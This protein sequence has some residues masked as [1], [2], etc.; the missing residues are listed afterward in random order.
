[1]LNTAR[2]S[3]LGTASGLRIFGGTQANYNADVSDSLREKDCTILKAKRPVGAKRDLMI[4]EVPGRPSVLGSH[5][6]LI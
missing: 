3:M 2:L 1:M 4:L 5:A 6:R